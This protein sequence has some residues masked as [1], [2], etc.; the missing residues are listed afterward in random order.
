MPVNIELSTLGP[1]IKLAYEGEADTNAFTDARATKVDAIEQAFTT[2]RQV[3][4]DA[5]DSVFTSAEKTKLGGVE[6]LA[7]VTD[8]ANVTSSISGAA[9]T[10]VTPAIDDKILIQDTSNSSALR[11]ITPQGLIDLGALYSNQFKAASYTALIGETVWVDSAA[12]TY[13]IT[14]PASPATGTFVAVYDGGANAGTNN[15]TVGRNGST[16]N[17]AAANVTISQDCGR[18]D[19]IYSGGTWKAFYSNPEGRGTTV[20][21]VGTLSVATSQTPAVCASATTAIT[22][23]AAKYRITYNAFD[24]T[25]EE[26][27]HANVF[28]APTWDNGTVRVRIKWMASTSGAGNV[29]WDVAAVAV[30]GGD[31]VTT[32]A[33]GTPVSFTSATPAATYTIVDTGWSTALTI[34]GT[35]ATYDYLQFLVT[36]K[37]LDAL[38]TYNALDAWFLGMDIEFTLNRQFADAT[39]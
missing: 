8:T 10:A 19:F 21:R 26:A 27:G 36:R 37:A 1:N 33:Y 39:N 23:D 30:S 18:Y 17:G 28:P 14:L 13:T 7:D 16:I 4:V 29:R 34:A 15:I 35:P 38:D 11:T 5:I 20:S 12:G 32:T 24:G 9:F 25:A 2:A 3:K 31:N 6:A 22:S